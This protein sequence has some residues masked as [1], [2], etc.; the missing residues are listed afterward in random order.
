MNL[1]GAE[2]M[3]ESVLFRHVRS[4]KASP[5]CAC[6]LG[7][8]RFKT[9]P[10]AEKTCLCYHDAVVDAESDPRMSVMNLVADRI[11]R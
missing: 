5:L 6:A 8:R 11:V 10:E 1:I 2:S 9:H 3:G 7:Q 4:K